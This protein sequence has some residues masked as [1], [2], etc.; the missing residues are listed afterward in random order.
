MLLGLQ[1]LFLLL[2]RLLDPHNMAARARVPPLLSG[3]NIFCR[4]VLLAGGGDVFDPNCD[5]VSLSTSTADLFGPPIW[6]KG[7]M[8]FLSFALA[9]PATSLFFDSFVVPPIIS[10][11]PVSSLATTSGG[12]HIGASP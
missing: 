4:L 7:L 6:E 8:L 10:A 12:H 9:P 11:R 1:L 5:D 2:L 3:A